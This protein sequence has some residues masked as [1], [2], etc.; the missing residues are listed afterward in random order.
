MPA[1]H[2]PARKRSS[3]RASAL[4]ARATALLLIDVVNHFHFPGGETL[5]RRALPMAEK[6][7]KLKARATEAHVPVIYVN[8]N[9]GRWQSDFRSLVTQCTSEDCRGRA[10]VERLRP[11]KSDYFVLKPMNSGF[12]STVLDTLLR[13]LG[14]KTLVLTGIATDNCVLFTAH[15]AYMRDYRIVAPEDCCAAIEAAEHRRA[16]AQMRKYLKA[17]VRPSNR[18]RFSG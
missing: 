14:A 7:V 1:I 3:A 9:F 15:D 12:F 16:I 18:I 6:L 8:D 10:V 5:A 11:T 4:P 13:Y 17:D 2:A